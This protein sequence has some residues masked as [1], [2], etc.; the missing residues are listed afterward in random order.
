VGRCGDGNQKEGQRIGLR[1][2]RFGGEPRRICA[3]VNAEE[4]RKGRA[5]V[6]EKV[7]KAELEIVV[8]GS[9]RSNIRKNTRCGKVGVK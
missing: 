7:I 1:G 6:K 3:A 8:R 5:E 9:R 4:D 2:G